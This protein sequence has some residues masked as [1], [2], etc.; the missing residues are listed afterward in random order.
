MFPE[1]V[2]Y[3]KHSAAYIRMCTCV[4]TCLY[5]YVHVLNNKEIMCSLKLISE[6]TET[7]FHLNFLSSEIW[8]YE[9]WSCEAILF[10]EYLALRTSNNFRISITVEKFNVNKHSKLNIETISSEMFYI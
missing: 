4:H 10:Y 8:S 1:F 5:V 3:E 6:T 2:I 7:K 9:I